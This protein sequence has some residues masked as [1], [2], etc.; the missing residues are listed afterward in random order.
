MGKAWICNVSETQEII[1]AQFMFEYMDIL[2]EADGNAMYES[3]GSIERGSRIFACINLNQT[4]EPVPGD[5]SEAYLTFLDD[6]TGKNAARCFISLNRTVCDNTWHS[7]YSGA[8]SYVSFNHR[9]NMGAK[10]ADAVELFQ[11]ARMNI[12]MLEAKFKALADRKLTRD[13]MAAILD[14]LFPFENAKEEHSTRRENKVR[15]ILELFENNDANAFPSIRGTG[16]NLLNAV[17]EYTDHVSSVRQTV[18]KEGMTADQI[19]SERAM[20]GAGAEWKRSALDIILEETEGA[21]SVSRRAES[22]T[23]VADLLGSSYAATV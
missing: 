12:S 20:F 17:T 4:F 19:R 7:N 15:S 9:G 6:R 10:M 18:G 22:V 16:Y 23:V 8:Q 1:Q 21:D 11:G 2:V 13:S 14:R 5:V 3:C